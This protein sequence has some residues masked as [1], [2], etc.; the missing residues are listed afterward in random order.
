VYGA[1][2]PPMLVCHDQITQQDGVRLSEVSL[3]VVVNFFFP[4]LLYLA[5]DVLR[6]AMGGRKGTWCMVH[7]RS[8]YFVDEIL[9]VSVAG[10]GSTP[11]G[12]TV[13]CDCV[14][15]WLRELQS[16]PR[17]HLEGREGTWWGPEKM[18]RLPRHCG[19]L[20]R[21]WLCN[22]RGEGEVPRSIYLLPQHVG[23]LKSSEENVPTINYVF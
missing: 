16:I 11:R 4:L 5:W 7:C 8:T 22:C 12:L 20:T 17:S 21:R 14:F 9:V 10:R 13:F 15:F 2:L 18:P 23:K 6:L 19:E 1:Q 3:L